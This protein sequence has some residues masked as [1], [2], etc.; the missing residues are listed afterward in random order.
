MQEQA[1]Q[2]LNAGTSLIIDQ[3]SLDQ[4]NAHAVS[5]FPEECCGLM[6]GTFEEDSKVK[7][8]EQL[9]RMANTYATEERYHRYTIDPKE[10]MEI[11]NEASEQGKEIVG[12]YHSHPNAPS[13]PSLFDQNHAWPTLSY[14]V[15]EVREKKPISTRSW[16]LKED[17]SDFLQEVLTV[18][19][20]TPVNER[21]SRSE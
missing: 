1:K 2:V 6:L 17:R 16:V 12:I 8:V 9:R 21:N 4:I 3:K 14:L 13:K 10:F 19:G 15:V 5:A 7:R 20:E 11:E 18:T